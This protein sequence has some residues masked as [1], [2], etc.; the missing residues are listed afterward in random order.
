MKPS[1][2]RDFESAGGQQSWRVL[3]DRTVR[4][5]PV[6]NSTGRWRRRLIVFQRV[7]VLFL[8]LAGLF[9]L[10]GGATYLIRSDSE[11]KLSFAA[12]SEPIRAILFSTDGVLDE[13]WV[14][15]QLNFRPGVRLLEADVFALKAQLE[16]HGQVRSAS[17]ELVFPASIRIRLR[18]QSPIM[19]IRVQGRND[20]QPRQR[21]VSRDGTLYEGE[22]YQSATINSLPFLIPFRHPDG[23]I[24]PLRGIDRVAELLEAAERHDR[25]RFRTWRVISLEHFSGELDFPGEIIEVRTAPIERIIF[26]AHDDFE[27]QLDRLDALL[28]HVQTLG[29]PS[30]RQ[31]DLS[32]RD[33]A[34]VRFSSGRVPGS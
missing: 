28:A 34:A 8:V 2:R 3:Q 30:I 7:F 11:N 4:S 25:S 24:Q 32:L 27:R 23:S 9:S 26:S 29:N 18:E 19:R 17:V 1:K 15:R 31:I 16:N 10:I 12:Q 13:A 21:L 20:A 14:S 5:A 22:R 6:R 33:S